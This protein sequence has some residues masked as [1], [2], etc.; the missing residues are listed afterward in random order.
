MF[1]NWDFYSL[2]ITASYTRPTFWGTPA[3]FLW[4]TNLVA[5]LLSPTACS[6]STLLGKAKVSFRVRPIYTHPATAQTVKRLHTTQETRVRYLG[7]KIRW[8]RKRQ[9][10]P[11]FMPGKSHGPGGLQAMGS[12]RVWH[13]RATSLH[14]SNLR[15]PIALH[16]GLVYFFFSFGH[17]R[18]S[19]LLVGFL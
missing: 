15:A 8:R 19:L 4:G 11:V 13:Y 1:S 3:D 12:Q 18:S 17:T 7:R 2:L 5:E 14:F 6:C 9:P 10:T 16:L